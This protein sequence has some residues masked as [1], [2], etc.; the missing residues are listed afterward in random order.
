MYDP[1][2]YGQIQTGRRIDLAKA[3]IEAG[4]CGFKSVVTAWMEGKTCRISIQSE[5]K[6]VERLG[7]AL[8]EVDPFQEITF[9][10]EGPLTLR[11]AS[12]YCTHPACPVPSGILKAVE[13]AAGLNLPSDVSIKLSN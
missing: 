7:E 3:E 11:M 1:V 8:S 9:R 13:L 4:A 12:Q 2:L 6:A 10:R 5:C